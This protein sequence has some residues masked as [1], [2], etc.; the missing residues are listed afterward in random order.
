MQAMVS[1][2][3]R[4]LTINSGKFVFWIDISMANLFISVYGVSSTMHC[5]PGSLY[6]YNRQVTAPY[7][8]HLNKKLP[9][10]FPK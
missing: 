1:P 2:T 5:N 6:A 3:W 10:I 9:W 7:L 4:P 8:I